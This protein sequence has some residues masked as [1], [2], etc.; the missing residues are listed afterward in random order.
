VKD[1]VVAPERPRPTLDHLIS[2][3]NRY[4]NGDKEGFLEFDSA[5]DARKYFMK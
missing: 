4:K 5:D 3:A 2:E 1:E